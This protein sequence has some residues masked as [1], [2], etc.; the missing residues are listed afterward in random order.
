[1]VTWN[2]PARP[3]HAEPLA[4]GA[5]EIN[6]TIGSPAVWSAATELNVALC[7]CLHRFAQ[8]PSGNID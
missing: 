6:Q 4:S 1:L 8:W 2:Q 7:R 3:E 5:G